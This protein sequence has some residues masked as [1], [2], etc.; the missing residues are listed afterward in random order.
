[1]QSSSS[2]G[3]AGMSVGLAVALGEDGDGIAAGSVGGAARPD[4]GVDDADTTVG[5][6]RCAGKG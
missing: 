1:M 3:S 2:A 5:V 4:A 6:A